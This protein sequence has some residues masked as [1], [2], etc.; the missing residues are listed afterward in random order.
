M[1]IVTIVFKVL[2]CG[3]CV[4]FCLLVCFVF[5]RRNV[6]RTP[7]EYGDC[8]LPY[9]TTQKHQNVFKKKEKKTQGEMSR[10]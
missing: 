2:F 1:Q 9:W 4:F 7:P 10:G 5:K 3:I 6:S 8:F